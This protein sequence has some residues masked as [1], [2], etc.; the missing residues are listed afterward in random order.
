MMESV[1]RG[2]ISANC[3]TEKKNANSKSAEVPE[4]NSMNRRDSITS[5]TV[6]QHRCSVLKPTP[7]VTCTAKT[8]LVGNRRCSK[9]PAQEKRWEHRGGNERRGW[10]K[11]VFRRSETY[12]ESHLKL[13]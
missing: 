9:A 6:P 2:T 1:L 7:S 3:N 12:M 11:L 8:S 4:R 5:V 13:P 10:E